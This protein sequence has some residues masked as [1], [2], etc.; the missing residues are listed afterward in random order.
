MISE[1]SVFYPTLEQKFSR[2]LYNHAYIFS[3]DLLRR[4]SR[5]QNT[6]FCGRILLFLAKF[7]PFSE[8]SGLNIISEFNLDNTTVFSSQVGDNFTGKEDG[9]ISTKNDK[10]DVTDE[11]DSKKIRIEEDERDLN[12]DYALYS[13]FWQLQDFF[14]NPIQCY[15]KSKWLLFSKH[16]KD[17]FAI[18]KSFKLDSI[19]GKK[20]YQRGPTSDIETTLEHSKKNGTS[21]SSYENHTKQEQQSQDYFAKYLT[22]QNLLQLQLSDSNFRRYIL[23][24]FLILFQYLKSAVKF[25]NDSQVLTDDQSRWVSDVTEQAYVLIDETPPNGP[26]FAKAVKHILKREEQWNAWKNDGCPALGKEI[27]KPSE[28]VLSEEGAKENSVTSKGK[29]KYRLI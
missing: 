28:S 21:V 14:R 6:V 5:T 19:S 9:E 24:Q 23:V 1:R 16:A 25:K 8:R 17:V 7:F 27:S 11:P 22:N 3:L 20:K 2:K 10:M 12:I 26:E 18:F 4:L 29:T 15:E 13:K